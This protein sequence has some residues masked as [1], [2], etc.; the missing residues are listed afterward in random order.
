MAYNKTPFK[1]KGKS[2]IIKALVG[3]QNNLP[4]ALKEK[5]KAA[6]ESPAK[7]MSKL[8]KKSPV[9]Q[10]VAL[11][12]LPDMAVQGAK[13]LVKKIGDIKISTKE[14]QER[15]KQRKALKAKQ[16]AEKLEAKAEKIKDTKTPAKK[17]SCGYKK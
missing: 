13:K 1:M 9:K 17:K 7:Q 4:D 16:K 14:G 12:D 8:K 10:D 15:R 2:P 11:G 5:I 6:P 3:K